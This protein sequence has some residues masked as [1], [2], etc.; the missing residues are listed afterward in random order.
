MYAN[1]SRCAAPCDGIRR[2][3]EST[4]RCAERPQVSRSAVC[5]NR[6][7]CAALRSCVCMSVS[8]DIQQLG[9]QDTQ[10]SK[11]GRSR[12]SA[13][14]PNRS[15]WA[16]VLHTSGNPKVTPSRCGCRFPS[17]HVPS[18][19]PT[20][21]GSA[22]A[23]VGLEN[24]AEQVHQRGRDIFKTHEQRSRLRNRSEFPDPTWIRWRRCRS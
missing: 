2:Y 11:C 18:Q 23:D 17:A 24:E 14:W 7:C 12:P 15:R 10:S 9:L 22:G 3:Q 6:L 20:M 19:V 13:M 5:P 8:E 16:A 4:L 1:R 21:P